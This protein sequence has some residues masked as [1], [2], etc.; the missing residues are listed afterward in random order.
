MSDSLLPE[1]RE[2]R[3]ADTPTASLTNKMIWLSSLLVST[4][5]QN[6]LSMSGSFI[7]DDFVFSVIVFVS[8]WAVT[9]AGFDLIL[10]N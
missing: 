9:V 1:R 8:V 4:L 2:Q 5:L 6:L 10:W 7:N 3:A